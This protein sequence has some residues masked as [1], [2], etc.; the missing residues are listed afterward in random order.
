VGSL[1]RKP[2]AFR[3][4]IYRDDLFPTFAFR[5]TWESLDDKLDDREACREFVKI[6]YDAARPDGERLVNDYLEDCLDRKE[7]P[8]SAGVRALFTG[9]DVQIPVLRGKQGELAD[10]DA[11]IGL[12]KEVSA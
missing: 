2:Q 11:L 1:I 4:Y 8:S 10:Y 12:A 3:R 6:L 9:L 7:I 5:Q